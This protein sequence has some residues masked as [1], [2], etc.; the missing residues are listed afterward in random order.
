MTFWHRDSIS[1]KHIR[2]TERVCSRKFVSSHP[3][4][5]VVRWSKIFKRSEDPK[6]FSNLRIFI[7][8][9]RIQRSTSADSR[10]IILEVE[11]LSL[12]SSST[13]N[14]D[15]ELERHWYKWKRKN[16]KLN[17]PQKCGNTLFYPLE[18]RVRNPGLTTEIWSTSYELQI[19]SIWN[20]HDVNIFL[21][22]CLVTIRWKGYRHTTR[23]YT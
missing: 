23:S 3:S 22:M 16:S 20:V 5:S 11:Y 12:M 14:L 1:A 9:Q 8:A 17:Y 10:S 2:R 19:D 4:D 18:R 6:Q 13:E 7:I 21:T 15:K